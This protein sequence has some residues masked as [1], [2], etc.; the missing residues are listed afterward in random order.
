MKEKKRTKKN[1]SGRR[2]TATMANVTKIIAK[3]FGMV[4]ATRLEI[5]VRLVEEG[6][7]FVSSCR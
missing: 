6:E 2:E 3:H 1:E 4:K 7:R 5:L